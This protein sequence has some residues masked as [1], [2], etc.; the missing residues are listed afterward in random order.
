MA[1]ERDYGILENYR[2][3]GV[4]IIEFA[5]DDYVSTAKSLRTYY[6]KLDRCFEEDFKA[7]KYHQR[8]GDVLNEIY[9]RIRNLNDIES[10]LTGEW[11]RQLT[12]LDID[13]LF[14]ETKNKLKEKGINVGLMGLTV[15]TDDKGV[16][17]F[18][19]EK[20][21]ANGKFTLYSIGVSS[22]NQNGG[23]NNGY[24]SCRFKKGVSIA[25]KTKI[26]IKSGFFVVNKSGDK[27]YTSLMI[28][29]YEVLEPGDTA[30]GDADSFMKIPEG[31]DEEVP[32]L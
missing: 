7:K 20:E 16:M 23:W 26:K 22:K 24:I 32:F 17:I 6:K 21:G 10:F 2:D 30:S 8:M 31:V 15:T 13:V 3:L 19:N 9:H 14:R 28:T 29:D 12:E 5:L 11:V 25:N 27:T 18:A 4:G 1:D